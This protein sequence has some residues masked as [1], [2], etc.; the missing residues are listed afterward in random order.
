LQAGGF[1]FLNIL[2]ASGAHTFAKRLY[3]LYVDQL[4]ESV[5]TEARS[6]LEVKAQELKAKGID[7]VSYQ[8]LKDVS[9]VKIIERPLRIPCSQRIQ[10]ANPEW[11]D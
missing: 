3:V 7:K 1:W 10:S 6:Y 5:K 2:I 8:P 9:E 4:A 11:V